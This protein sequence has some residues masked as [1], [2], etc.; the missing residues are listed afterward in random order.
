MFAVM[1][2]IDD[3]ERKLGQALERQS[4]GLHLVDQPGQLARETGRVAGLA[5]RGVVTVAPPN[6]D[7]RQKQLP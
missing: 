7:R 5:R 4:F 2:Q 6:D 1:G 3:A